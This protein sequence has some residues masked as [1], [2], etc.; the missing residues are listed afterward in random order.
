MK[1]YFF[2]LNRNKRT[3]PVTDAPRKI[4]YA[5]TN[6]S[7]DLIPFHCNR[8]RLETCKIEEENNP[9]E[10]MDANTRYSSAD[11]LFMPRDN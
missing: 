2:H 6:F 5:T 4:S 8:R 11:R 10:I 1:R 9:P 7:K 3:D